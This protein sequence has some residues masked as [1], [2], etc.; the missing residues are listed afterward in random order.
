[1]NYDRLYALRNKFKQAALELGLVSGRID[2]DTGSEN[3]NYEPDD[4]QDLMECNVLEIL[5]LIR[6][7]GHSG[8]S[9]VYYCRF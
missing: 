7:Q 6:E 1:M 4:L 9:H 8:F 3:P 5:D 2:P